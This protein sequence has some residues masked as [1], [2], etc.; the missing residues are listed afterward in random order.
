MISRANTGSVF[1]G[2]SRENPDKGELGL[3]AEHLAYVIYTSGSTGKPKGV[4]QT[5]LNACRLF[6]VTEE[7]SPVLQ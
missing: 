2:Y 6:Y 4:L 3:N 1:D 7:D 5:H